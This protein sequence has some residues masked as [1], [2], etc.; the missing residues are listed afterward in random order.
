[1]AGKGKG[2]AKNGVSLKEDDE[3]AVVFEMFKVRLFRREDR[4]DRLGYVVDTWFQRVSSSN[5]A[6]RA[7]VH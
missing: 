1:V 5:A 6:L 3:G 7:A 4:A 2:K